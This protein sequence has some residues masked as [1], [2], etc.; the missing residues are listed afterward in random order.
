MSVARPS[1]PGASLAAETT[2]AMPAIE[3]A[4][5]TTPRPL[6]RS[7]PSM[8][9]TIAMN[10]GDAR[11]HERR[12]AG[13]RARDALDEEHLI[14]AVAEH[15]E[16]EQRER[17]APGG[18]RPLRPPDE[19]EQRDRGHRDAHAVVRERLDDVVP[20]FTTVKLM[21]QMRPS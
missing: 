2:N 16:R 10:A 21:P 11:D 7:T 19:R 5:P 12:V 14:D 15:A 20:Y 3:R 8:R 9:P 18:E 4:M 17:V 1:P 13:A 6:I